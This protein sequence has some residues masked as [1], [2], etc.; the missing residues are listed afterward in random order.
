MD[1]EERQ[2]LV[3]PEQADTSASADAETVNCTDGEA[4]GDEKKPA[5]KLD[6]KK[7]L[8]D[9]VIIIVSAVILAYAL[10]HFVIIK[11]EIIS[12][13]MISTLNVDDLVVANRLAYVFN[14]PERGDIIFFAFP[15]DESLTY[16]KR[17]IGMP[18]EKVEIKQRKVFINDEPLEEPYLNERMMRE[19]AGPFYVPEGSYFVMGD[20]RNISVDSRYWDNKFVSKAAIYGKAWFRYRPNLQLIKGWE[21]D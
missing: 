10:T 13:S 20:N 9:W 11:T 2:E 16:V 8:R 6:W 17:I 19:E 14:E 7:E 12:G 21:Y 18:G 3:P 15:D 5:E 1:T 4:A